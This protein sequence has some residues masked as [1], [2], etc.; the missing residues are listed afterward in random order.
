MLLQLFVSRYAQLD[1]G[2]LHSPTGT[3]SAPEYPDLFCDRSNCFFWKI[4][5][6][7]SFF[8]YFPYRINPVF[9]LCH[10]T[11]SINKI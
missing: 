5:R 9:V 3:M 1:L 10:P 4:L 7:G 11:V 6:L 8:F 2:A